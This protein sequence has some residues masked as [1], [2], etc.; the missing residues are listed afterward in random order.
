MREKLKICVIGMGYVGL[1]LANLL[2]KKF[3][4]SGYDNDITK[5]RESGETFDAYFS[6]R[7]SFR[8]QLLKFFSYSHNKYQ[9]SK[10]KYDSG[11]QVERY[12]NT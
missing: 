11:H 2:S 9:Y 8:S 12:N 6:F 5:I 3:K 1:P 4:V 10:N 7:S